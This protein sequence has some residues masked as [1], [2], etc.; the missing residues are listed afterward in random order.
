VSNANGILEAAELFGH[1]RDV[2]E[3]RQQAVIPL[4]EAL[5]NMPNRQQPYAAM[6]QRMSYLVSPPD[7]WSDLI[8]DVIAFVDPLLADAKRAPSRWDCD[9]ASWI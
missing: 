9:R 8:A 1:I 5:A 7:R 4:A 3:H 2:A 6:V